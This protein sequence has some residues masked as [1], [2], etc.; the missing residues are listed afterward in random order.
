MA[1]DF[2]RGAKIRRW[3]RNLGN[4]RA[5]LK[6]IG[7][8]M[9]AESTRAFKVQRFGKDKWQERGPVNVFGII[10][11]FAAGKKK[12]PSHRFDRRP[13]LQDT[14]RLA[15]SI[16]FKLID[17]L[18][19]EVGTNLEYASVHHT[20][21]EVESETITD[22]VQTAIWNWLKNENQAMKRQLGFLLNPKLRDEKLKGEVPR[23]P[24]VGITDQT[25]KD[26]LAA[27]MVRIME[28]E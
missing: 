13:A 25:R 6:Q 17:L 18:T 26:V 27:V 14:G 2:D 23:R 20:G 15:G 9:A 8:L 21:G 28:A 10:A 24:L 16:A 3:D 1:R 7:A 12:P 19:V 4:P 5:A 22:A 11:D